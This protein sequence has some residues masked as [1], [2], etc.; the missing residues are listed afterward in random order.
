MKQFK[1]FSI[2][3]MLLLLMSLT[4][5]AQEPQWRNKL[6]NLTVTAFVDGR[7]LFYMTPQKIHWHHLDYEVV[8]RYGGRNWPTGLLM[9][10]QAPNTQ[11]LS[12]IPD[13]PCHSWSCGGEEVDS[14]EF[15]LDFPLPSR[16]QLK[17]LK[18]LQAPD[19]GSVTV[20]QY[21][22]AD[23]GYTTIIDFNDDPLGGPHFYQVL[24]TFAEGQFAG[25][26]PFAS[27]E[28]EP[29]AAIK[30]ETTVRSSQGLATIYSNLGTGAKVYDCCTALTSSGPSSPLGETVEVANAFTPSADSTISQVQVALGYA[31]GT[32]AIL[33]SIRSDNN[34]VPGAV[35]KQWSPKTFSSLGECCTLVTKNFPAGIPVSGGTQY[36]LVVRQSVTSADA[37]N[38]WNLNTNNASGPLAIKIAGGRFVNRGTQRQGAFGIFGQ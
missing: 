3:I 33:V 35:I 22:S 6:H 36:W 4:A 21:P 30:G 5:S 8:G 23:N 10:R 18:V 9:D 26:T 1:A 2:A 16:Y 37:W 14:S 29:D 15:T 11:Y 31:L 13:W 38:G 24:L 25:L 19:G 12:W 27:G 20:Y 32:K 17:D 7:D 34:G 28:Q